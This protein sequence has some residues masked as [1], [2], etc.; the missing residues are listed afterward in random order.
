MKVLR[1]YGERFFTKAVF[2]KVLMISCGAN[3][4]MFL[5]IFQAS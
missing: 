5:T 4:L 2:L 3:S 1:G